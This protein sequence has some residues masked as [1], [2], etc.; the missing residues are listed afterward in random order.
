MAKELDDYE[1]ELTADDEA[2]IEVA[3]I[4]PIQASSPSHSRRPSTPTLLSIA[5]PITPSTSSMAPQSSMG[6]Q[7]VFPP[8]V[9][10][11]KEK[12]NEAED[13]PDTVSIRSSHSTRSA[14][15]TRA[16]GG[17]LSRTSSVLA[18][19]R[20]SHRVSQSSLR[21]TRHSRKQSS[22]RLKLAQE[23]H[24][25]VPELPL[26]FTDNAIPVWTPYASST[27]LLLDSRSPSLRRQ[28]SLDTVYTSRYPATSAAAL[29]FRGRSADDMY[30][31]PYNAS[32][33]KFQVVPRS[34]IYGS[35]TPKYEKSVY[36]KSVFE[37]DTICG[38][39]SKNNGLCLF[40]PACCLLIA[41]N[42]LLE[43]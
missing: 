15:S 34:Q 37:T 39:P 24:P 7:F 36:E 13:V 38:V 9:V 32:S 14:K 17:E 30:V 3:E 10:H 42:M 31:R 4:V 41:S 18:A 12:E 6:S 11:L 25:P 33:S 35:T 28:G 2:I 16:R 29:A 22:I 23:E 19:K 43:S 5:P 21:L 26:H 1:A 8:P 27:L 40:F 20:R